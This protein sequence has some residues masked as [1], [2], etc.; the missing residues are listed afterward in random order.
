MTPKQE[1]NY[2]FLASDP[3]ECAETD[4]NILKKYH[5]R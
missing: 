1:G 4:E 3:P 2:L 5:K